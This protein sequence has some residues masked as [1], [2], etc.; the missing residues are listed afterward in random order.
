MA[1]WSRVRHLSLF[2][3]LSLVLA[4][5]AVVAEHQ[6]CDPSDAGFGYAPAYSGRFFTFS[7][8]YYSY[9][10]NPGGFYSL[11]SRRYFGLHAAPRGH[12]GYHSGFHY[13]PEY[14]YHAGSHSGL[15]RG[16]H[17]GDYSPTGGYYVIDDGL[18]LYGY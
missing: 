8:G 11:D 18:G 15:H 2:V 12:F 4:P 7:P 14:G 6:A 17:H 1:R 5:C 13:S 16:L 3:V 9:G 10:Y